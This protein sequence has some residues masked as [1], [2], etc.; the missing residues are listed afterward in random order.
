MANPIS[1][2]Q[3]VE[4]Y[5][6]KYELYRD[7]CSQVASILET[8]L[9]EK[10]FRFQIVSYRPKS[11]NSA[12]AKFQKKGYK[13][14]D[15][16]T[17]LAGCRVIFYL[18]SDIGKFIPDIYKTFGDDNILEHNPKVST[19]S[20]NG[21]HLVVCLGS[22][23]LAH[24][25]YARFG[26]LKCEIQL[27]TVLH[28]AWS[29]MEHD[30]VYKPEK[31]LSAFDQTA[32]SA[33]KEAF[34]TTMKDYIQ[35]AVRS[36]EHIYR[37]YEKL[38]MGKGVFDLDFFKKIENAQSN[39]EIKDDLKLLFQYVEKFGDKAPKELGLIHLIKRILPR[40]KSLKKENIKTSFG[41]LPGATYEDVVM[42][43][44][45]ILN[46][47]PV[48]YLHIQEVCE[49]CFKLIKEEKNVRI[50]NEAISVLS[51]LCK[52][53]LYVLKQVGYFVQDRVLEFTKSSK[54][55]DDPE[56]FDALVRMLKEILSFSFEGTEMVAFDT[57]SFKSGSLKGS[58]Q[59][60][61]VRN[62]A[63]GFTKT[64]Y[65]KAK[66][67]KQKRDVI[68]TLEEATRWPMNGAPEDDKEFE[69]IMTADIRN[70]LT[71]YQ[72]ILTKAE[73]EVIQTIEKH[74]IFLER[75][76]KQKSSQAKKLLGLISQNESY[77]IFK[78]FV[79]YDTSFYPDFDFEKAAAYRDGKIQEY[80]KDI[81]EENISEWLV[82][83]KK[84]IKNYKYADS[85]TYANFNRFLFEV[86][87]SKPKLG[88]RLI[89]E[90]TLEPFLIHL[91][92]G[93]WKSDHKIKAKKIIKEWVEKYKY[94]IICAN[95]FNYV[96]EID[97][98]LFGKVVAKAI[99]EKDANALNA[100]A[101]SIS[102][103]YKKGQT[104]LRKF[105]VE[106]IGA[107]TELG[108]TL[109]VGYVWFRKDSVLEDLNRSDFK[110]IL[111]NLLSQNR[112][113]YQT[114][115]ILMPV[116]EKYPKDLINFLL[117]RI[118]IK[119]KEKGA[120]KIIGSSYDAIPFGLHKLGE[121]LRKNARIVIPLILKWYSL[122]VSPK[123]EWLYQW[124]ASELLKR[125]FPDSDPILENELIKIIR[126]GGK[127]GRNIA[128]SFISKFEGQNFLWRLI[129]EV[130]KSYK[131]EKDYKT[132]QG[133]LFGY[134]SQTGVVA[135]EYGF[136]EAHSKKKEALKDLKNG[137]S[138]DLLVFIVEYEEY[139]EKL[140]SMEQKRADD[141]LDR[142]KREFAG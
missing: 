109:W 134:L 2:D 32:F 92:S 30:I 129:E 141:E 63:I 47:R 45:H 69:K 5:R 120:S 81:G 70:I 16:V 99:E 49:I 75:N 76:P 121:P 84:V 87:R 37:E 12:A 110:I 20:Y 67:V 125:V 133:N 4:E 3:F 74:L 8:V 118:N 126:R 41:Q 116:A 101:T 23:R 25:E 106:I 39:N 71:F 96:E 142:R 1:Q 38:K 13:S 80:V 136:V 86:A 124:E 26:K 43:V 78:V 95:I 117:E 108:N 102:R 127:N 85:G 83:I 79:G 123:D 46:L 34:K 44:F 137:V 107:L 97:S 114:E 42:E 10:T 28:H 91:V 51:H 82:I 111:K 113:E 9:K 100:L 131:D 128:H 104:K 31:E 140:I 98:S 135:G 58:L 59:L 60:K 90:K 6:G 11:I 88:L 18:E 52:Y 93:L 68:A 35:P 64:L 55:I 61:K 94:L 15:D 65:A 112:I 22:D 66:N 48:R 27:T 132:L 89:K 115:E 130:I 36:F 19:D 103:N 57:F 14:L 73:N 24:A 119:S 33:I 138:K 29:E 7:F 56:L 62:S 53:D 50:K 40:A 139:L 122:N 105:F 17:D 77:Q 72:A 54:A 21:I